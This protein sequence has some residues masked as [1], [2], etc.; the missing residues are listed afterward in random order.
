[1]FGRATIRLGIG[2]HSSISHMYFYLLLHASKVLF[3]VLSV[4][5]YLFVFFC[6]W[7]KYLGNCWTNFCQIHREDVFGPSL[8][9]DWMSRSK[10]K[11]TRDKYSPH[12]KCIVTWTLQ[13]TSSS[14]RWDHSVAA[15]GDAS[16]AACMQFMFGKTSLALVRVF[17]QS[18]F[19]NVCEENA[20]Q[21]ALLN[22]FP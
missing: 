18:T 15:G 1:M 14:S 17:M 5:F 19:S 7:I 10:V 22:Q 8:G 21:I 3:L 6:L 12:W 13:I 4:T 2:P 11:V 20:A 9:W 16:A